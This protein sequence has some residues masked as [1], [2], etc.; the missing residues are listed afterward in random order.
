M[1]PDGSAFS[2][3]T[4]SSANRGPAA[5]WVSSID[6]TGARTLTPGIPSFDA[7]WAPD[8]NRLIVATAAPT[9]SAGFA[10][11]IVGRETASSQQLSAYSSGD[12]WGRWSPDGKL[13]SF[14]SFRSG[15]RRVWV[16]NADGSGARPFTTDAG[17]ATVAPFWNPAVRGNSPLRAANPSLVPVGS[18][19][20]DAFGVVDRRA[21]VLLGRGACR[22]T[23]TLSR[24][25][26]ECAR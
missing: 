7:T 5:M 17:R 20:R 13:V 23:P 16:A 11:A 8:A 22:M 18:I 9:G 12:Q 26:T 6:G 14:D 4:N 15:S 1:A 25:R 3:G 2:F 24:T 21:D 19:E 10:L